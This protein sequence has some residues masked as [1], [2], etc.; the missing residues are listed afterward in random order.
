MQILLVLF[1]IIYTAGEL[2]IERSTYNVIEN[3]GSVEICAVLT[4]GVMSVRTEIEIDIFGST[5]TFGS[6]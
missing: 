5:A 4:G 6:K 2:S 3:E 1:A